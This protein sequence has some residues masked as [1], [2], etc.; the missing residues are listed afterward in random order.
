MELPNLKLTRNTTGKDFP[1]GFFSF[2]LGS[3]THDNEADSYFMFT[4]H[5]LWNP[6]VSMGK[7][8]RG[9]KGDMRVFSTWTDLAV[10]KQVWI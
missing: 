9:I 4:E 5:F 10:P 8:I 6:G 3:K 1:V 2:F 7:E